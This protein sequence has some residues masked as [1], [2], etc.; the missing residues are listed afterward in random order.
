MSR[1]ELWFW[2]TVLILLVA[3]PV[4]YE[5][6]SMTVKRCSNCFVVKDTS[7]FYTRKYKG[8][9]RQQSRCKDCNAEVV[10]GY[11]YRALERAGLLICNRE[12]I[13]MPDRESIF[14]RGVK[15]AIK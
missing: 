10:L 7:E 13:S 9:I 2:Y 3:I 6:D 8:Q 15:D 11:R 4:I 14:N 12:E 5:M 1:F